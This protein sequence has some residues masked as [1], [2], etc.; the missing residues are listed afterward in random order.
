MR[1]LLG[2]LLLVAN[3]TSSSSTS[4]PRADRPAVQPV[5]QLVVLLVPH[6]VRLAPRQSSKR[7]RIVTSVRPI[8]GEQTVLPVAGRATDSGGHRWLRVSLP[9]RPN[10][11]SGWIMRAGTTAR[12][13]SWHVFVDLSG[14]TVEVYSQGR[15][16]RTFEAVVGK[17]A[18]PT[19]VGEFFVE[20]AVAL[21]S[22]A[23]GAPFALALSARS[24]VLQKFDGGPGQIALHGV[25]NVGGVAGTAVS[26]GCVRLTAS[27]MGW[28]VRRIG[29]GVPVT[30]RA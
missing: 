17:P 30:I 22:T 3:A 27:A 6:T 7:L 12:T 28:L 20:E 4:A 24:N 19:P 11:S 1:A 13:T 25:A 26:H 14:R 23:V 10:G 8:T 5:Q 15:E 16:V 9:G 2:L 21:P 18:T 29:P